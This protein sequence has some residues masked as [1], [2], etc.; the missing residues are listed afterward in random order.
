VFDND[1]LG[2]IFRGN[3][4]LSQQTAA[5]VVQAAASWASQP[6]ST[7]LLPVRKNWKG[8]QESA[9]DTKK[10][11]HAPFCEFS[12]DEATLGALTATPAKALTVAAGRH[13]A[14]SAC[15]AGRSRVRIAVNAGSNWPA[16]GWAVLQP[17]APGHGGKVIVLSSHA[18]VQATRPANADTEAVSATGTQ[19]PS[20]RGPRSLEQC[21]R[22][23]ITAGRA[24]P[25]PNASPDSDPAVLD[26]L[27]Q[28]VPVCAAEVNVIEAYLGDVLEQLL[29]PSKTRSEPDRA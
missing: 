16:S 7:H 18:D 6:V 3:R 8:A 25:A 27:G 29:A 19:P 15:F 23:P 17:A 11:T 20:C 1:A 5:V 2:D 21:R 22:G 4:C 10:D 12:I 28:P 13:V 14:P 26:N 24:A 9:S